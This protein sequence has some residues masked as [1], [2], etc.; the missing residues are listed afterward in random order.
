MQQSERRSTAA[1]PG[2]RSGSDNWL[3]A[4][5]ACG[6]GTTHWYA[7]L[8]SVILPLMVKDLGFSYT[9]VGLLMTGRALFG[10]G[11]NIATSIAADL[12]GRRKGMLVL[13]VS[14]VALC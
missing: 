13:S 3:L 4:L 11:G 1:V 8:L 12:G 10:A 14:A 6:H 9:Q 2:R 5:M 7:G